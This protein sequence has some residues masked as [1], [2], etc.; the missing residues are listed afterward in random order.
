MPV[1][2]DVDND[3]VEIVFPPVVTLDLSSEQ[4]AKHA[5]N[6][7]SPTQ[8]SKEA[9]NSL[10]AARAKGTDDSPTRTS[11][12][13]SISSMLA[14]AGSSPNTSL[15]SFLSKFDT[16]EPFWRPL[17]LIVPLRLGL[18]DLNLSYINALKA[19]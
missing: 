17:L 11:S 18:H 3:C 15:G 5:G 7:D 2:K 8:P 14:E 10:P 4:T 16:L 1:S 19:T 6:Q 12:S 9:V 13:A